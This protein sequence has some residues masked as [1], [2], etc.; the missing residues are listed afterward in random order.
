MFSRKVFVVIALCVL[1]FASIECRATNLKSQKD[2]ESPPATAKRSSDGDTIFFEGMPKP[3][4]DHGP[5][6]LT[7]NFGV[8][9]GNCPIGYVWRGLCV[10]A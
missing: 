4:I 10:P 9:V 8:R 3:V 2:I 7:N 6:E 5:A 1:F